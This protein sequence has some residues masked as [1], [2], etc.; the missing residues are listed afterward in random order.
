MEV[1]GE[2]GNGREAVK[3]AKELSPDVVVIDISMPDLNGIESTK[4]MLSKNPDIKVVALSMHSD[5]RFIIKMLTAGA[6]GYVLK[7]NAFDELVNAIRTVIS[8]QTFLCPKIDDIVIED[9]IKKLSEP[10]GAISY[11]LSLR[12]REVFQLLAE[13]NTTKQIAKKL[14]ISIKT[15]ESHRITM[16]KKLNIPSIAELTKYAIKEGIISVDD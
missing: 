15:V 6:K 4:Q 11:E 5:I 8:N 16:L 10:K 14:D 2:A 1:V 13:G 9:Y 7:D 12:E 3:L